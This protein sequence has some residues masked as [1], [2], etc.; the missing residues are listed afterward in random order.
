MI[1]LYIYYRV[2]EHNASALQARVQ[3]MQAALAMAHGVVPQ[4]KRRP[5]A[6]DGELTWM[7]VYPG[8][9]PAF[10]AALEAAAAEAGLAALTSGA[11]H[12][13][14]FTELLPCA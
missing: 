14:V 2:S 9:A 11:R 8:V 10:P 12:A 13:E 7:E 1:D 3:T 6:T 4:L 5:Q